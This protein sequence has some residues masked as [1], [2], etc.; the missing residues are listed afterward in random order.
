MSLE[1]KSLLITIDFFYSKAE[2]LPVDL[3]VW[4]Q[5]S[6][7][8]FKKYPVKRLKQWIANTK[9]V[10]KIQKKNHNYGSNK[11]TDYFLKIG[12]TKEKQISR[13]KNLPLR[14]NDLP[15]SNVNTTFKN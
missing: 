2:I 6:I 9:K 13:N 10:F 5:S 12:G 3:K 11:I 4:F 7:E 8:E 1:K 15:D 14:N